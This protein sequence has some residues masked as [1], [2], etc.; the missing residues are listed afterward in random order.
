MDERQHTD[1]GTTAERDGRFSCPRC[2]T[3]IPE[4]AGSVAFDG[5][6]RELRVPVDCPGCVA[7]LALVVTQTESPDADAVGVDL[8]LEDR[9]SPSRTD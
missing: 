3:A 6:E 1:S 5:T 4:V 8:W 9:R 7:P 2:G